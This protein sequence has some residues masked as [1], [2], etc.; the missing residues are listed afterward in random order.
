MAPRR[1]GTASAEVG[2]RGVRQRVVGE[3][4]RA[5][6]PSTARGRPPPRASKSQRPVELDD[7]RGS[8]RTRTSYKKAIWPV[9]RSAV[10][11]GVTAAIAACSVTPEPPRDS[12]PRPAPN[13]QHPSA[14]PTA[15]DTARRA[16]RP[17]S[18]TCARRAANVQEAQREQPHGLRLRQQL[19]DRRPNRIAAATGRCASRLPDE[20]DTPVKTR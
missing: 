20:A 17:P 10:A 3:T 12:A 11:A 15:T 2:A 6:I 7:G 16:G 14:T 13:L 18:G 9:V 5:R 4:P 19:D 1:C 8:A